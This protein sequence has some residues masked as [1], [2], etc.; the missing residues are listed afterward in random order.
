MLLNMVTGGLTPDLTAQEARE[1]GFSVIIFPGLSLSQV[2]VTVTRAMEEL[3]QTGTVKKDTS[4]LTESLSPRTL[5]EVCGLNE[6]MAFDKEARGTA[7]AD[8]V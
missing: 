2:L 7:F 4:V 3:K 1:L 8:G 6:C 5:F